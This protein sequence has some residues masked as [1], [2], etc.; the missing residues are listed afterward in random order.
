MPRPLDPF[1][2]A[3]RT[4]DPMTARRR[5]RGGGGASSTGNEA[6]PPPAPAAPHAPST[7]S[8]GPALPL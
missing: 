5:G 6:A 3:P 4:Q 8:P 7:A 1:G 2:H